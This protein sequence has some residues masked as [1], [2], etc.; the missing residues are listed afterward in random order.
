MIRRQIALEL[1][2]VVP[3]IRLRDNIQLNPNQYIIKIK[4]IQV[5]E[6]EILFDHYMAMNP[7][8]VEDEIVGI[9]TL[10]PAFH[11]EAMWITESQRERAESLGYT[12]VDPPSIIATH[13]TEV[14]K[15]HL[16]ELLTRQDVQNLIDNIKDNNKTLV[17]EL[18]P[19]LLS[20]GDIQKVLQNLLR[21][22]ISIRDLVTIFETLADYAAT[23]RDTDILTE[24]VRQSLTCDLQ[25]I[26]WRW[27]IRH[28][29][30]AG[31]TDRADDHGFCE[32]N[33]TGRIYLIRSGS[34][35]EHLKGDGGRGQEAGEQGR[36]T[37]CCYI[38]DCSYVF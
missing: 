35:E 6:G 16:D 28:R 32:A 9:P 19:K 14:I 38:T 7:G 31:S 11:L 12:V 1:G 26:F 4:G 8:Y 37:D 13:L 29:S 25:Q 21:E 22:G 5:S 10:E 30:D 24:Y 27:R 18:V 3:I 36:C 20:V 33:R 17:D 34:N 15:Q 2:A 23:S